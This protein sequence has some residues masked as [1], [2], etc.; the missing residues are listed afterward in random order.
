[1]E[2]DWGREVWKETEEEKLKNNLSNILDESFNGTEKYKT[3]IEVLQQPEE[4][5]HNRRKEVIIS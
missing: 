4:K 5:K 1:M 2:E 3:K